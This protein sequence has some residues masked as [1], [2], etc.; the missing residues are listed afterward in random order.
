MRVAYFDCFSGISGDMILGALI[1]AGLDLG[2]LKNGLNKLNLS[3]YEIKTTRVEKNHITAIHVDVN[4]T[5][6]QVERKLGDILA[7]IDKSRLESEIKE[8][9]KKIFIN[10]AKA[11][12]KVHN[13]NIETVHFHELGSVDTII[14]VVGAIIAVRALGIEEIYASPLHVGKGFIKCAHGT[15][16]VPAPATM[17]LLKDMPIYGGDINSELVT[18]TGAAIIATMARS[19]GEL[20]PMVIKKI[21]Y[22]AGERDL[23][24]PN[25]LRVF[26]GAKMPDMEYGEDVVTVIE[27]NIDDMNPEFYDHIMTK[28][29]EK[30]ALDVFLTPI[31]M[32]RNRPA[33]MLSTITPHDRVKSILSVIFDETTTLG[34]RISEVRRKKALREIRQVDTKFGK[35]RV[36]VS[37]VGKKIKNI[38]PE[39]E[40]CE[41]LA[42]EHN[43]PIKDVYDAVQNSVYQDKK[44]CI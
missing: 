26:V 42:R 18:P 1:D 16:P 33:I 32:K 3:G 43:I 34:V 29:F 24:I 44:N 31:H 28:L 20:P 2:E 21:G 38:T 41:R 5:D 23:P 27:T 14:D 12:A 7:L 15:L 36:K 13:K 22:G 6:K 25:L 4:V 37:L 35:V 30:G 11:E 9:G 39:Y 40:D 10:L 8:T 17:E 19:F